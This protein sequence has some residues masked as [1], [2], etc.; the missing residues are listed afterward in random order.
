MLIIKIILRIMIEIIIVKLFQSDFG[1]LT[2]CF[3][4]DLNATNL[5]EEERWEWLMDNSREILRQQTFELDLLTDRKEMLKSIVDNSD[6][7]AATDENLK[8]LDKVY[9]KIHDLQERMEKSEDDIT[10]IDDKL[11]EIKRN[12]SQ[13]QTTQTQTTQ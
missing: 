10:E 9:I 4:E 6:D 13:T 1:L 12:S 7:I 8:E 11:T 3:G 5:S 2:A